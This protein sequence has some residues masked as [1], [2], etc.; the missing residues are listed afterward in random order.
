MKLRDVYEDCTVSR[1]LL[2]QLLGEREPHESI[3]HRGMPHYDDHCDFVASRPY[4]HW[5]LVEDA[6]CCVGAVYLTRQ[7]EI[8][9]GIF[10]AH[11]GHRYGHDAV[12]EVMR[13]HPGR[14]LANINPANA[15]SIALFR[16]LGFGPEPIQITLE[17]PA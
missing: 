9:V 12:V 5:Y 16:Q 6:G 13:L 8:G 17:R 14:L 4:A 7:G 15:A 10:K 11:R 2:Y 1:R 3:S